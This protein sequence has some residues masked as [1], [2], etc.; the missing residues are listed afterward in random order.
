MK[1]KYLL[2]VLCVLPVSAN[3]GI[4]YRVEQIKSP[5][6]EVPSGI[7]NEAL[8]R[9]RRFYVGGAYNFSMWQNY[10]D[11]SDVSISGNNTSSFEGYAGLRI[12]DTFRVEANYIRTDA[13]WHQMSFTGDTVFVNAIFDARIDN[14]YRAFRSQMIV[15]YVGFGAGLSWNSAGDGVHMDKKIAPVAAALAGIGVEFN[16]V[17]ALDFGYRYFYMFNPGVDGISDLNPASHQFRA[18]ARISF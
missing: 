10:T 15:P 9:I 5:V 4:P 16:T 1:I 6:V 2:P 12:Y 13:S 3:A 8:A 18:G 11:E 7:D 14:I 17:F